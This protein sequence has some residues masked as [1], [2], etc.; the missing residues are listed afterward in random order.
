MIRKIPAHG[1]GHLLPPTEKDL[2]ST[3]W[4]IAQAGSALTAAHFALRTPAFA[5]TGSR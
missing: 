1:L 3:P 4:P 5:L 2:A